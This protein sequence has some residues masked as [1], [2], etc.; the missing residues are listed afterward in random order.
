MKL[1]VLVLNSPVESLEGIILEVEQLRESATN[2]EITEVVLKSSDVVL[3]R[4]EC[5]LIV[6]G[7]V[8][9][10]QEHLYSKLALLKYWIEEDLVKSIKELTM[11]QELWNILVY[12][13]LDKENINWEL[14][15]QETTFI[16]A[17]GLIVE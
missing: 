1:E 15:P 7:E 3:D 8:K 4:D 2:P 17:V 16:K 5:I 11:S 12:L 9:E 13:G 10:C 14:T 6:D